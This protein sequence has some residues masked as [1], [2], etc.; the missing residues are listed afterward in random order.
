MPKVKTISGFVQQNTQMLKMT[1]I[2]STM[3]L[4]I[5]K[6]YLI[7]TYLYCFVKHCKN[8]KMLGKD[9]CNMQNIFCLKMDLIKCHVIEQKLGHMLR[10]GH[11]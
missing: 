4:W 2:N 9:F 6:V 1:S 5:N 3:S 8:S 10:R 11:L 7:L